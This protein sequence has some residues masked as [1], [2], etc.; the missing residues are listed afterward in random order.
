M[1]LQFNV[2]FIG[3]IDLSLG[4]RGIEVSYSVDVYRSVDVYGRPNNNQC[5]NF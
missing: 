3:R 1:A 4:S 2:D 5:E